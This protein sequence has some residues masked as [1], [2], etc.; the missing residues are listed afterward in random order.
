MKT[1]EE[2]AQLLPDLLASILKPRITST[3]ETQARI[4]LRPRYLPLDSKI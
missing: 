2:V 1:V 3:P 4:V